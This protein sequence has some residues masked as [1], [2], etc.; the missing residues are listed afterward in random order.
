MTD[1]LDL[2]IGEGL[3]AASG[4]MYRVIQ[5]LGAGGNAVAYLVVAT[6][7]T[8]KGVPFALKVFHRLSKPERRDAFL[9]EI[10]FLETCNTS[11]MRVYDSGIYQDQ[12]PF[13][14]AEYLPDTLGS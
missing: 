1:S 3:P 2:S 10:K 5:R 8:A 13:V 9:Q 7:G 6:S 14:V 12:Y 11:I 4:V